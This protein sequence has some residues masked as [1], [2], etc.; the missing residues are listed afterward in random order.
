MNK[1]AENKFF[2]NLILVVSILLFL[3][4]NIVQN[5]DVYRFILTGMFFE[6][7][8]V[9]TVLAVY[10]IPLFLLIFIVW[11]K[12]KVLNEFYYAFGISIT[13]I[14]LMHVLYN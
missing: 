7:T 10:L 8:W 2:A 11:N 4:W 6:M 1:F 3:Y 13:L 14:I 5:F 12:F 9:F